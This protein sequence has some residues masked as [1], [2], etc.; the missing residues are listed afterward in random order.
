[1]SDAHPQDPR[2]TPRLKTLLAGSVAASLILTMLPNTAQANVPVIDNA[3][4]RVVEHIQGE[5]TRVRESA[6]QI[7]RSNREIS[8][9]IGPAGP[10]GQ[11][12]AQTANPAIG[13]DTP[14][15]QN[16]EQLRIDFCSITL[17][18]TDNGPSDPTSVENVYEWSMTNFYSSELLNEDIG[19]PGQDLREIRRRAVVY[20]TVKSFAFAAVVMDDL[21]TSQNVVRVLETTVNNANNVREDIKANSF[22]TLAGYRQQTQQLGLMSLQLLQTSAMGILGTGL[23]HEEGGTEFANAFIEDDFQGG[24]RERLTAPER[25]SQRSR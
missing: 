23:Y 12:Q 24:I 1:M 10:T 21:S 7:E 5:T 19:G 9:A 11:A 17:C 13:A 3:V 25:G 6:T 22:I 2:S 18:Q 20:A 16:A 15:F 8:E 14:F 4:R